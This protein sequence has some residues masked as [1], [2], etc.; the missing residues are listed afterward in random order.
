MK[1]VNH[2]YVTGHSVEAFQLS[3]SIPI[4]FLTNQMAVLNEKSTLLIQ[5]L[6]I[7]IECIPRLKYTPSV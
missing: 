2:E 7:E 4:V 6:E 5:H 3:C 1:N